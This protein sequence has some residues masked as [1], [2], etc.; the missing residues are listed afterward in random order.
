MNRVTTVL[1]LNGAVVLALLSLG[2]SQRTT[3]APPATEDRAV[4]GSFRASPARQVAAA[5]QSEEDDIDR[6]IKDLDGKGKKPTPQSP[7]EIGPPHQEE[8]PPPR[9]SSPSPSPPKPPKPGATAK[10]Q[11]P[12]YF[13][14]L[15]LTDGQKDK[16]SRVGQA[17]DA[18]IAD[19]KEKLDAARKVRL[20]TAGVTLGLANAIKRLSN[21][22]QQAVENLLTDEQRDKLRQLRAGN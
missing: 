21:Q 4:V 18:K 11:L 16:M 3:T 17:Y 9:E 2:C 1:T 10:V 13:D 22:R 20:G 6:L 8:P 15:D 19:L 12:R 7:S 5:D 14:Q